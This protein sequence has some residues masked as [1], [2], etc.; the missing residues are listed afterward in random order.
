MMNV[1]RRN[2]NYSTGLKVFGEEE[3]KVKMHA[4]EKRRMWR[5][6]HLEVDVDTHEIIFAEMTLINVAD[7]EV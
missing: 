5:K 7:S 6:L 4:S 2:P 1:R 3:C